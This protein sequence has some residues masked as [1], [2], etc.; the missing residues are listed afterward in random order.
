MFDV[1]P[2]YIY[3]LKSFRNLLLSSSYLLFLSTRCNHDII[4][5]T[6][7]LCD[8]FSSFFYFWKFC[9]NNF[10]G[11]QCALPGYVIL[12]ISRYKCLITFH[13]HMFSFISWGLLQMWFPEL[14]LHLRSDIVLLNV[15]Y[16]LDAHQHL[17]WDHYTL[18]YCW[19][20]FCVFSLSQYFIS[21]HLLL[22]D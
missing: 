18:S 6:L 3:L 19:L 21:F 13:T 11:A 14:H 16:H 22:N 7:H 4:I 8:F 17:I 5:A 2:P 12:P 1:L 20:F 9:H 15:I 10:T